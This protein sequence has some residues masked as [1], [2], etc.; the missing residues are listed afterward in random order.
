VLRLLKQRAALGQPSLSFEFFPPR[1]GAEDTMWETFAAV[2]DAKADFVSVTYGAGGSNQAKSF[3]V[4]DRMAPEILTVGHLTCVGATRA[5]A[6]ATIARFEQA[7][8]RSV[9]ALRGDAPK[10]DPNALEKG[11][12]KTALELVELVHEETG[13]EVGVAAFPE[14]HPE[15]EN[16]EHDSKVLWMKQAAG[17]SYA[18][19]QLFFGVEHYTGLVADSAEVGVMLPIIPGLMPVSNAK[20]L[21]RMAAMSGAK[22]PADL[23][24]KLESADEATARAIGMEYTIQLGR[25]LLAAGAPGLH[26]FTL[27]KAE[28]A[29]ELAAGVGLI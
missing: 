14:G 29:L 23:A 7:G 21:L 13:L 17:A 4:L 15:S 9:L 1:D 27:N 18:M 16:L 3:E 12:L 25:D 6:R 26:I 20:Q 28:A 22:V 5:S 10:D 19:T 8:V 11:Q 24:Q 2:L